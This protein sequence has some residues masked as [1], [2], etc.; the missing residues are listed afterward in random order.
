MN[1]KKSQIVFIHGG[2]AYATREAYL[3]G[4]RARTVTQEDIDAM[5]AGTRKKWRDALRAQLSDTHDVLMPQ[6]PCGWNARYEEWVIWFE[7]FVP[8][9]RDDVILIGH[10]MGGI[11]LAKYLIENNL[12]VR[13]AQLHLVAAP[14]EDTPEE[15]LCDFNIDDVTQLKELE[16]RA[17]EI[18]IY[19][20]EDD[21]VVPFKDAVAYAHYMPGAEFVRFLDR[22][23]FFQEDFPELISRVRDT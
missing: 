13:I 10:S 23:H 8:F 21:P 18:I 11:F 17:K 12:P 9:L 22:G 20:S 3:D 1:Q 14:I 5:L 16:S 4:L 19:H 2:T 7:K 6:M 15:P